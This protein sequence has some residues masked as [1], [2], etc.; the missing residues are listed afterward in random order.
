[1]TA[2]PQLSPTDF[3]QTAE[4][5]T[6]NA[7]I[8]EWIALYHPDATAEWIFEGVRETHRGI[9][10]ISAAARELGSIWQARGLTVRKRVECAS[11]STIVLS[12]TGGFDGR[13]TQ[14][15]TEIWTLADSLV[16]EHRMFGHL[17]VRPSGHLAARVR[18]AITAPRLALFIARRRASLASVGVTG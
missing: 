10:E 6:N 5:I 15:G 11:E 14:F 1:M 8:D 4:R 16:I 18:L 12:W 9:A 13:N 7:L 17:N 3:A 2:Q